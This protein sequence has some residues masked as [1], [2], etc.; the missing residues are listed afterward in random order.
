[1]RALRTNAYA[2]NTIAYETVI[3]EE[4]GPFQAMCMSA[5]FGSAPVREVL[6]RAQSQFNTAMAEAQ[7]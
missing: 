3:N 2:P 1:M 6:R 7:S 4:S 5:V